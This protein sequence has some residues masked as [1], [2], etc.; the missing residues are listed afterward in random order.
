MF[1]LKLVNKPKLLKLKCNF[2]FPEIVLANLQTK[3]VVPSKEV[4]EVK[5]DPQYDGLSKVTVDKIP[6][7]YIIPAGEINIVENGTYDVKE[8]ASAIVDVPVPVLGTKTITQNGIYKASDDNLG[9]YSEV[10]VQ[11]SG[12]DINDYFISRP[13][14]YTYP[15]YRC[16]K[17]IPSL[18]LE[19]QTNL[20]QFFA[21]FNHLEEIGELK[22]TQNVTNMF[23]MF[24]KCEKL[25]NIPQI[26]TSKVTNASY[27]F[28]ECEVITEIPQI[29]TSNMTNMSFMFGYDINL[30]TIP[31]LS[32]QKATNIAYMFEGVDNLENFGGLEN[33]G[34]NYST[35]ASANYS[36]YTLR[37][38]NAKLTR[39]S[40]MNV[41]NNLYDI[42]TKG[43]KVQTLQLGSTNINKLTAE[44]IAIAT[45][46]GW[47]VS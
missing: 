46:L 45:G 1:R 43:V 17:K 21:N 28:D 34:Q 15:A 27:M 4:Q 37:L 18:D 36:D 13:S 8:K 40:L 5:A 16:I 20:T 30:Q 33:I 10:D 41:I 12:V 47:S 32:G 23:Q 24:Q 9:G 35:T 26:D 39:D 6:D 38:I 3:E 44:E 25:R 29:N 7:E 42:A 14:R 31:K 22:N 19:L 2:S 11:T